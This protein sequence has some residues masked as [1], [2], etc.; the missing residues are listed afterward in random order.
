MLHCILPLLFTFFIF[1][2][3]HAQP[4]L[5][6]MVQSGDLAALKAQSKDPNFVES[7]R[8][9][10]MLLQYA[11][12]NCD[13]PTAQW[14]L[15]QGANLAD[16]PA[17]AAK[18]FNIKFA[19]NFCHVGAYREEDEATLCQIKMME[20]LIEQG[21]AVSNTTWYHF[22]CGFDVGEDWFGFM[23]PVL[24]A[25][26]KRG[27]KVEDA[28]CNFDGNNFYEEGE[29][30]SNYLIELCEQEKELSGTRSRKQNQRGIVA[31]IL[32]FA[33]N[34]TD[35]HKKIGNEVPY[36]LL[37]IATQKKLNKQRK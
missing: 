29:E 1:T 16:D 31:Q 36:Q 23:K 25:L 11:I 24:A 32:F 15:A 2:L 17:E 3:T 34:G 33:Q 10:K 26:F 19:Y 8:N 4:D 6:A 20:M 13:L 37:S 21:I 30:I 14:L 12:E 7:I 18:Q 9:N 5:E 28:L 27:L 35:F 22:N